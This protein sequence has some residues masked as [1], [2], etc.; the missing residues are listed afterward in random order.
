MRGGAACWSLPQGGI[1]GKKKLRLP[2]RFG[3]KG[4]FKSAGILN[5][6]TMHRSLLIGKSRFFSYL[7]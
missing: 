7:E 4:R 1:A 2:E 6:G 5:G 3:D